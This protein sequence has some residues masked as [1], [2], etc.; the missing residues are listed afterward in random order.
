MEYKIVAIGQK[1]VILPFLIYGF[2]IFP[3]SDLKEGKE[4]I[5]KLKKMD[6]A[7]LFITQDLET[8]L[9]EEIEPLKKMP[10][11]AIITIPSSFQKTTENIFDIKKIVERAIGSDII[12]IN[13]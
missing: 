1:E 11:P 8:K 4:A 6:V 9:A 13:K 3:V 12:G 7:I 10:L 5:E 2:E